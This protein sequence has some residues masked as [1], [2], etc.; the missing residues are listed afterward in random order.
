MGTN[1]STHAPNCSQSK[2]KTFTL[3]SLGGRSASPRLAFGRFA[4]CGVGRCAPSGFVR[5]QSS[6]ST[7]VVGLWGWGRLFRP[8]AGS[9]LRGQHVVLG[10]RCGRAAH[11][12][13]EGV[14]PCLVCTTLWFKPLAGFECP[15]CRR[16]PPGHGACPCN[17]KGGCVQCQHGEHCSHCTGWVPGSGGPQGHPPSAA[18]CKAFFAARAYARKNRVVP[19]ATR[20]VPDPQA[21]G[22][23]PAQPQGRAQPDQS[24]TGHSP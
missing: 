18:G 8:E 6:L 12:S 24:Q 4:S 9:R 17:R 20:S 14:S 11:H 5:S 19:Q 23:T 3:A 16:A 15:G 13:P 2:H 1:Q 7:R 10:P 21:A 22:P